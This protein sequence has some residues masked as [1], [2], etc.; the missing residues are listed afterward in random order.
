MKKIYISYA[1]SDANFVHQLTKELK[2]KNY[3]IISSRFDIGLDINTSLKEIINQASIFIALV[4]KNA[5]NNK[6]FTN[7]LLQLINYT[8]HSNKFVIPVYE[9][10]I[11]LDQLPLIIKNIH[12]LQFEGTS[13]AKVRYLGQKID[14]AINQVL[15]KR[16]ANEEKAKIIKEKIESGSHKYISETIDE[17]KKRERKLRNA[18]LLWYILG[19]LSL[20]GGVVAV[21]IFANNGLKKFSMDPDYWS[22][23]IFF[24]IKSAVVIILLI[25]A[26]KYSFNLAKSYTNESL[27]ISDRIHAISFGKFYLQ[28]YE[29]EIEPKE[30][31]DIF[32]NWNIS[33]RSS[34]MDQKTT[35]FDPRLIE[36]ITELIEKI[37]N[38]NKA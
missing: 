31:K 24:T 16:L 37:K 35:D 2:S 38:N 13:S 22:K 26:S 11:D 21:L 7:E 28:V 20:L 9:R 29:Q 19:F 33:S 15:G 10:D 4:T 14:E 12:G 25:S 27:K 36:K 6:V 30:L 3:E 8:N 34:F 18:G 23:T 17:L 1:E 32:Q 5:L